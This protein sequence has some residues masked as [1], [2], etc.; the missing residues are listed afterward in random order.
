MTVPTTTSAVAYTATGVTASFVYTWAIADQSDLVVYTITQSG[1]VL[2]ALALT[3]DYTVTGVG[4]FTGGTVTL[5]AGNPTAGTLVFIASDPAEIQ[6]L[7]LTQGQAFSPSEIMAA[8]DLL[9]REVQATR[10]IANVGIRIPV[11][12]SQSGFDMVLP[13][14]AVRAGATVGFDA[15]GDLTLSSLSPA[16]TSFTSAATIVALKAL[17]VPAN[18]TIVATA[19]YFTAGD[20][21][22]GTY[23]YVAADART[24]NNGTIIQPNVGSGR[25]NLL[26]TGWLRTAQFGAKTDASLDASAACQAALNTGSPVVFSPGTYRLDSGIQITTRYQQVD[27]RAAKITSLSAPV[28]VQASDVLLDGLHYE[29]SDALLNGVLVVG[30]ATDS[31]KTSR[32]WTVRNPKIH[33][34]AALYGVVIANGSFIGNIEGG[35][36]GTTGGLPVANS[37]GLFLGDQVQTVNLFGVNIV[38]WETQVEMRGCDGVGF[39]QC[40][41]G[42]GDAA[43]YYW[44]I[45]AIP[46][47]G[48]PSPYGNNVYPN[49]EGSW[50][51]PATQTVTTLTVSGC[52]TELSD[53]AVYVKTGLQLKCATFQSNLF[54]LNS[55]SPNVKVGTR[56]FK[57]DIPVEGV[58]FIGNNGLLPDYVFELNSGFVTGLTSLNNGWEDVGRGTGHVG[59][60]ATGGGS[61]RLTSLE[62]NSSS[63]GMTLNNPRGI[64]VAGAITSKAGFFD[65]TIAITQP[66]AI[67]RPSSVLDSLGLRATGGPQDRR[68]FIRQTL[69]NL[70]SAATDVATLTLP[71]S[72]VIIALRLYAASTSLTTATLDLRTAAGGAGTALASAASLSAATAATK[73]ISVTLQAVATTDSL[74]TTTLYL[75]NVTAQ[76]SAATA[77][78]EVEVLDL[79][80]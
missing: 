33:A 24:A 52:Y 38:G 46:T 39:Y 63:Q 10:R 54:G 8:L 3:T 67:T 18:G 36:I 29:G 2:N 23:V 66:V 14:A 20:D 61:D 22:N 13:T 9:T 37:R 70:N 78:I 65:P 17:T 59:V 5:T 76:G 75:R 27:M 73:V 68:Q 40:D 72:Y 74:T 26:W 49:G 79:T 56:V 69:V 15:A 71:A 21:G 47:A 42:D 60:L 53:I 50:W 45:N 32:T 28:S 51:A 48:D 11:A 34:S 80:A 7:L 43:G 25:W 41:L 1:T 58:N 64:T 35:V 4:V 16:V 62:Y 77:T 6:Q 19:G 57:C 30:S 55:A 12:E 31:S 44:Y